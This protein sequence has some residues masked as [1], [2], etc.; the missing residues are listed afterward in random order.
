MIIKKDA[1]VRHGVWPDLIIFL[2]GDYEKLKK[3]TA[4]RNEARLATESTDMHELQYMSRKRIL[5]IA[6]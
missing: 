5:N 1:S 3:R 6:Y 4:S 2:N